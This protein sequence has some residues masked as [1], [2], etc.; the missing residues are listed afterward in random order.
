MV[1]RLGCSA[2]TI[3]NSPTLLRTPLRPARSTQPF[4]S[5]AKIPAP[6]KQ[7]MRVSADLNRQNSVSSVAAVLG[8]RTAVSILFACNALP[9]SV[10]SRTLAGIIETCGS[11][12]RTT[13]E[14]ADVPR[15]QVL[16]FIVYKLQE[17][18]CRAI[19]DQEVA[20]DN[21]LSSGAFHPALDLACALTTYSTNSKRACA[22]TV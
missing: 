10:H 5:I 9:V 17:D 12:S 6:L 8:R 21:F 15:L 20:R 4:G 14:G 3:Q 13:C 11:V 1:L 7:H 16:H 2:K 19:S 18:S 22:N